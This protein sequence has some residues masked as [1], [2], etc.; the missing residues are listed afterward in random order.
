MSR[1]E[2]LLANPNVD[3]EFKRGLQAGL[4]LLE[5]FK[6]IPVKGPPE[7]PKIQGLRT[8]SPADIDDLINWI[9][10]RDG[11]GAWVASDFQVQVEHLADH[12]PVG[13]KMDKAIQEFL[14]AFSD[15][16]ADLVGRLWEEK[17]NL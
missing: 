9:E 8:A 13:H 14:G 2:S 6:R 1:L 4:G 15:A 7:P 12:L 11:F 3:P 17:E 16:C 10:G 5:G